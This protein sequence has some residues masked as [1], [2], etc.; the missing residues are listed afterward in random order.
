RGSEATDIEDAIVVNSQQLIPARPSGREPATMVVSCEAGQM[1]VSFAFASQ[2][3]SNTGDISPMTY[4]VDSAATLVRTMRANESNTELR[5]ASSREAESFLDGLVGGTNVKVRMTP[6]RQRSL[7]VD[8]R[9]DRIFPKIEA[10]R[11]G[12]GA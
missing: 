2:F 12:C 1:V 8:F 4:Q 11:A 9:I 7:T 5:F 3:V 6:V 10:L